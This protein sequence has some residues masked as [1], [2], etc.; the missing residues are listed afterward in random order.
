MRE[1][2]HKLWSGSK[3]SSRYLICWPHVR[4]ASR[5]KQVWCCAH[6]QLFPRLENSRAN[7]SFI[8]RI[9]NGEVIFLCQSQKNGHR[10]HDKRGWHAAAEVVLSGLKE[11]AA[12][13]LWLLFEDWNR[14]KYREQNIKPNHLQTKKGEYEDDVR[15]SSSSDSSTT[16]PLVGPLLKMFTLPLFCI[17][18]SAC[19]THCWQEES[20]DLGFM[21]STGR[22]LEQRPV[23]FAE[24]SI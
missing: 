12:H 15:R 18:C 17:F 5:F 22:S 4:F 2:H 11:K 20:T 9:K 7:Q 10:N 14:S 3:P 8:G 21:C 23:P 6:W 19:D 24:D 16:M 13:K 1:I